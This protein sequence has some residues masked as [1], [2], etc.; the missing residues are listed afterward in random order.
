MSMDFMDKLGEIAKT[1][2]EKAGD[3]A[4]TASE[5]AGD[6]IETTKLSVQIS[7]LRHNIEE[8]KESLG[9]H[10]WK[11]YQAGALTAEDEA[12]SILKLIELREEEIAA[13]TAKK[14]F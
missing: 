7:G 13:L 9:D 10:Y 3:L 12:L 14:P 2:S 6:T 4:K 8:L 11:K 5:K 1:A